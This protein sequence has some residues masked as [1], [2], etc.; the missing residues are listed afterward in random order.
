[1]AVQSVP[2]EGLP[3]QPAQAPRS[4]ANVGRETTR[5][6]ASSTSAPL[7]EATPEP[8]EVGAIVL[9]DGRRASIVRSGVPLPTDDA[10]RVAWLLEGAF[11]AE[12]K[13][14]LFV[15]VAAKGLLAETAI[16]RFAWASVDGAIVSAAWTMTPRGDSR[17]G[18]LG[19]VFTLPEFRGAGLA[20]AVCE[21][22]LTV[23]DAE[24]G[25]CMFL[26]TSNPSAARIYRRLGFQPHPEGLMRRERPV[27]GMF[28]DEWFAPSA[29]SIRPIVWGDI[30]GVV[31]LYSADGPLLSVCSMQ[32]L[33]SARYVVHNRCNSLFKYTWQATRRGAWL[34][35]VNASGALVGTAA[36][37]PWGNEVEVLGGEIDL[38][39]H[40][41]FAAA[42]P[43]LIGAAMSA[44]R[45]LGW[46]WL[47]ARLGDADSAKREHLATAGFTEVARL[48]DALQVGGVVHDV[49]IL[50]AG[51]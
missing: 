45:S 30:P 21:A 18:T 6:G 29:I 43:E 22:L 3:G 19:E 9:A 20:P 5:P 51:I 47:L 32:G 4:E 27:G 8:V 17:I 34:G 50:R 7:R 24:G 25:R 15:T 23:F 14:D 42:A 49:R 2:N 39:V 35:M 26:A 37:E 1:M 33:Y 11:G 46:R 40:A 13:P 31:A 38:T 44:A 16:D 41:T 48:P 36:L 28:D 12:E 10:R